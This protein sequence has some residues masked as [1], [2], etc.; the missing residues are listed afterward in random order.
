M[1][2]KIIIQ[3]LNSFTNKRLP[4]KN[5]KV[6]VFSF[7]KFSGCILFFVDLRLLTENFI[8][9]ICNTKILNF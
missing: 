7:F 6:C 3:F 8:I 2:N 4:L 5:L 1:S 9:F